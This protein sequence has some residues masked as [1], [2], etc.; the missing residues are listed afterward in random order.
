M[1]NLKE[2]MCRILTQLIN[3]MMIGIIYNQN[4][5]NIQKLMKLMDE[6]KKN[7]SDII[8]STSDPHIKTLNINANEIEQYDLTYM[9]TIHES[10]PLKKPSKHWF[11][12]H[13][14]K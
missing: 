12:V 7:H 1:E 3:I 6:K 13:M 8:I 10:K 5:K 9:K 2:T 11:V 14:Y 4:Y